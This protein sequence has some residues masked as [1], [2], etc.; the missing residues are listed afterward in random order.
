MPFNFQGQ[1]RFLEDSKLP[2]LA[3]HRAKLEPFFQPLNVQEWLREITRAFEQAAKQVHEFYVW[4][5]LRPKSLIC[6]P[7]ILAIRCAQS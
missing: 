5:A 4:R 6:D 7:R 2:Q 3:S 1:Y